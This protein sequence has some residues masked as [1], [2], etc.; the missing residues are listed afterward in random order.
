MKGAEW[1]ANHIE[2]LG[3]KVSEIERRE[4]NRRRK[5]KIAEISDDKSKYRV[6]LSQQ[7]GKPY[8]TPWIKARTLS[9]G[10]VKIDVLYSV[11]EQ[12][13]VVSES[14]ELSDAQI[15]FSTYSD[16][17]ARENSDT[18]F[19]IKIG[20]TVIEATGGLV[21][22]TAAKV[23][24]QSDSVQ[25]GGDGGKQVARIGDL[26]HVMSGSSSGKWPIVEGSGKVFA[27]D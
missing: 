26:V 14:G 17:N 6:E 8:L 11:G 1:L 3:F 20:D 16:E 25:L 22:V 13:D 27:I 15:D 10:G 24:V 18:P 12:V 5:G 21:K 7:D 4:R 19:H 9:A 2:E 23:I